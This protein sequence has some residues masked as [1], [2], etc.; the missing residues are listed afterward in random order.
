MLA[1]LSFFPLSFWYFIHF[2]PSDSDVF[3]YQFFDEDDELFSVEDPVAVLIHVIEEFPDL[4]FGQ[5]QVWN[6]CHYVMVD[7]IE[8]QLTVFIDIVSNPYSLALTE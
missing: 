6:T 5:T 8:V 4:L 2:N 1:P 3:G 7:L